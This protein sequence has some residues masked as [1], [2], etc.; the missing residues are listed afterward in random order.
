MFTKILGWSD[1]C[2]S[3]RQPLTF[4]ILPLKPVLYG[5][6]QRWI[7]TEAIKFCRAFCGKKQ[8]LTSRWYD[9][10]NLADLTF[11]TKPDSI[12]FTTSLEFKYTLEDFLYPWRVAPHKLLCIAVIH[13]WLSWVVES[14]DMIKLSDP[15]ANAICQSHSILKTFLIYSTIK[16]F[17]SIPEKNLSI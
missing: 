8:Q 2:Y 6:V 12:Q 15:W 9:V 13:Y 1:N 10:G 7:L 4:N 17:K 3:H 5:M 11:E 16:I 14:T